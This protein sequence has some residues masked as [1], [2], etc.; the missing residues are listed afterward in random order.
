MNPSSKS[1]HTL[2]RWRSYRNKLSATQPGVSNKLNIGRNLTKG[3]CKNT[4]TETKKE[5]APKT[6]QAFLEPISHRQGAVL[7]S[8][9]SAGAI[10][11]GMGVYADKV[12]L[13]KVFLIFVTKLYF[14]HH[15]TKNIPPRGNGEWE[16]E[17][18]RERENIHSSPSP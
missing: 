9:A 16:R 17:W 11:L 14:I 8:P 10:A 2:V 4:G 15:I 18:E 3:A 1:P 5:A 12:S 13:N 7:L 6:N